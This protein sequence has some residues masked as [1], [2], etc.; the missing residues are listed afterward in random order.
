MRRRRECAD[1]ESRYTTYE[2]VEQPTL[3]VLKSDGRQ[4]PFACEKLLRGLEIA[5]SKRDVA[6]E[7]LDDLVRQVEAELRGDRRAGGTKCVSSDDVGARA[8]AGLVRIDEAAAIRFASVIQGAESLHGFRTVLEQM[9]AAVSAH[10]SA[11]ERELGGGS[12]EAAGAD[13]RVSLAVV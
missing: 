7:Q 9:E 8:L 12:S 3:W 6:A 5:C 4:E 1:C 10:G 11:S 13:A 2:R